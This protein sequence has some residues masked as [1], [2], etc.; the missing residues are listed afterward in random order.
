M[1]VKKCFEE[2]VPNGGGFMVIYGG[3][4]RKQNQQKT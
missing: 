2:N 1:V 4:I 3:T